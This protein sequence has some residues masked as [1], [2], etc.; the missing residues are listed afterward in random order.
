MALDKGFVY[1]ES[2]FI[3]YTFLVIP[4]GVG[5]DKYGRYK[6][7]RNRSLSNLKKVA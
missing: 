6:E 1:S 7:E 2:L 4:V 3:S 5:G